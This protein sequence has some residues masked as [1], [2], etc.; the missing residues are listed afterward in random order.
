[1][2][3]PETGRAAESFES[4]HLK[5]IP[6]LLR[7]GIL[8]QSPMTLFAFS[9]LPRLDSTTRKEGGLGRRRSYLHKDRAMCPMAAH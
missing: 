7:E 9:P 1:M 6:D 8:L 5:A 3:A 2:A 4:S